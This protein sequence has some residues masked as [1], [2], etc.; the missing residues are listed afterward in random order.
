[1]RATQEVLYDP[2]DPYPWYRYMRETHPVYYHEQLNLWYVY[3]HADVV[4]ILADV[5]TFSSAGAQEGTYLDSSFLRMDPPRHGR[6]RALVSQAFTPRSVAL[7]EPRITA[8][9]NELL[10]AVARTGQM[11]IITD[12][13]LPLPGTVIMEL[14]GV[15]LESR[16]YFR[17]LSKEFLDE[18]DKNPAATEIVTEQKLVEFLRPLI[19][20][21]RANPTD[22][23]ISRLVHAEVDGETLSTRDIQ[24]SCILLLIAGYETTTRLIGNALFCFTQHPAVMAELREDP[25]LLPGALEE[26]LRYRPSVCG[27]LRVTTKDALVGATS[28]KAGQPIIVQISSANR[29]ETAFPDPD[30]FDIRR[31][32]NR[33]F[34]FGQGIHFCLGAPLAR[35]ESKIA[36]SALLQRF[37]DLQRSPAMQ[38]PLQVGPAGVFQGTPRFPITF[39]PEARA[40]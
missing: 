35:L 18:V 20:A 14:F 24:A 13:G 39:A 34:G 30:R 11:D 8:I 33:H 12:L 2:S 15:P 5:D 23:L 38:V 29:D 3:R 9:V 40:S 36:V 26:V 28:I 6:Y 32:P 31:K 1:M 22:D 21:R 4:G 10:D 16:E 17:Q 19:E 27:V 7:L 25:D 37:P